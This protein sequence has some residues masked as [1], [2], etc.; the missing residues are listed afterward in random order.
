L[1]DEFDAIDHSASRTGL[2]SGKLS[3][4]EVFWN[5]VAS[6]FIEVEKNND[7]IK[8]KIYLPFVLLIKL[9]TPA[10]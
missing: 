4:N 7:Y 10:K 3:N 5:K 8:L 9:S 1:C 6:A 2:D